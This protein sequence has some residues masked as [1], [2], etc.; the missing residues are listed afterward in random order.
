MNYLKRYP[1]G[2]A[3]KTDSFWVNFSR[4]ADLA[5]IAE[6][7]GGAFAQTVSD[8]EALPLAL[9]EAMETVKTGRSAVVDVRIG[10]ISCQADD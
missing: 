8:P 7:A 2:I 5:K 9:R 1:E 10:K 6:A 4:P 3:K